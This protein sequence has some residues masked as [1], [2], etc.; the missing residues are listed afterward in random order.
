MRFREFAD[1]EEQLA[2]LRL[3]V[4]NTWNALEQYAMEQ[5]RATVQ[6]QPAKGKR[7]IVKRSKLAQQP[8]NFHMPAP[9][10]I[11]KKSVKPAPKKPV[12][13]KPKPQPLQHKSA[14]KPIKAFSLQH[15]QPV[16]GGQKGTGM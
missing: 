10:L 12:A 3:I 4:D 2:L 6:R 13:A 11:P 1:T 16:V 7:R 8:R 9:K 15:S 5:R 14:I